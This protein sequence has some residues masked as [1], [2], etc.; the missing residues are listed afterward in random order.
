MSLNANNLGDD[1]VTTIKTIMGASAPNPADEASL[2]T[3]MRALA[4]DIID[5]FTA[6]GVINTTVSTPDT[7][8]GTG[9]GTIS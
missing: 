9:T 8:T 2:Q 7:V 4:K 1:F 6:N 3:L 5:H